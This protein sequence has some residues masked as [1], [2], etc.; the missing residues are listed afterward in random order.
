MF[1]PIFIEDFYSLCLMDCIVFSYYSI[2]KGETVNSL[3]VS[4]PFE[5][6]IK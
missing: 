4:Y 5:I 3:L 6:L 1:N 2:K